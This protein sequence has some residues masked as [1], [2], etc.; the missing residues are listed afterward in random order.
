MPIFTWSNL[1]KVGFRFGTKFAL[2]KDKTNREILKMKTLVTLLSLGTM[3]IPSIW[4]CDAFSATPEAQECIEAFDLVKEAEGQ[5]M[6]SVKKMQFNCSRAHDHTADLALADRCFH[7]A[8]ST[9]ESFNALAMANNHVFSACQQLGAS[10][11]CLNFRRPE[12]QV[13]TFLGSFD[14]LTVIFI[15]YILAYIMHLTA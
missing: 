14:C 6:K 8:S 4:S 10:D 15:T 3:L 1:F 5:Y 11:Q 7:E 9:A 12:K 13:T 2:Y